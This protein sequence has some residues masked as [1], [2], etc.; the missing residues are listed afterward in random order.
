MLHSCS[1]VA[2]HHGMGRVEPVRQVCRHTERIEGVLSRRNREIE[3][4]PA[5]VHMVS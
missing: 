2:T 1:Q 5:T 3:G 4:H